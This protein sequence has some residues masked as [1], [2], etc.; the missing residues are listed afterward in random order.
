MDS[1]KKPTTEHPAREVYEQKDNFWRL[2]A[3]RKNF[4]ALF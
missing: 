4:C 2:K 3:Y 1:S